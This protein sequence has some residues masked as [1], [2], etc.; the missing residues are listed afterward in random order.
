MK[1]HPLA[2]SRPQDLL[3]DVDRLQR[4]VLLAR[5]RTLRIA[6]SGSASAP[7][8]IAARRSAA[9][10]RGARAR[11]HAGHLRIPQRARA[12]PARCSSGRTPTR[13]RSRPSG[14]RS[15]C[16]PQMA[17][18]PMIDAIDG[19]TPTPAISHAILDA[20]PR[21]HVG[22]GRRHR[23]HAV[24]QSA[25]RRRLQVQPA[26]RRTGR[27]RRHALDRGPG[28]PAAVERP[29]RRGARSRYE[30]RASRAPRP[31]RTTMSDRT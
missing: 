27:H 10:Q 14:R 31:T 3:V 30:Q 2:G 11:D 6:H 17:S 1:P 20:Q 28:Q 12:S 23:H 8:V 15:R 21:P 19:Y 22:R 16:S 24:A 13:S 25:R 9:V 7:A 5:A 29:R 26:D 4:R 18:R